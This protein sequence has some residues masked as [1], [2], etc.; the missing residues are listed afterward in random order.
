MRC[1]T[2]MALQHPTAS[3]SCFGSCNPQVTLPCPYSTAVSQVRAGPSRLPVQSVQASLWC[4]VQKSQVL[5]AELNFNLP[6][7]SL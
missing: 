1:L 5:S 6:L 4:V 2:R 7:L 3:L